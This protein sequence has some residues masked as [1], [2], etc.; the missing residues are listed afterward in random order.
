MPD[1][2][3]NS[4]TGQVVTGLGRVALRPRGEYKEG[5]VYDRLVMVRYDGSGWICLKDGSITIPKEGENWTLYVEKG[6]TGKTGEKGE[7]GDQGD[8]GPQG[9]QGVQGPQGQQG[10]QGVGGITVAVEG[11]Y[12]FSVSEEGHLLVHYTGD[13]APNFSLLE[14]GH[15]Y[16]TI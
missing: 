13:T 11:Q 9:P 5:Q 12:G 8:T 16:L 6:E 4:M 14:D 2:S 7:K 10:P 1:V 15:L 3:R